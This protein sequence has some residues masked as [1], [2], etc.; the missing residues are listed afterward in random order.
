MVA[1]LVCL[2]LP[3]PTRDVVSGALRSSVMSPLVV[4]QE[5]AELGRRTLLG[6]DAAVIVADS[7]ALRALRLTG[8]EQ[9]NA[10]LRDLLGLGAAL[11][12]GFVPAEALRG[13]GIGDEPT[14][15]ISA[16]RR[17]GV[18]PLAPVVTPQ[19]LL[20]L[21]ERVDADLATVIVWQHPDF[22]VS[23]MS[24]D[25]SAYGMAQAHG[26]TGA[27]RYFL[28]M[29]GVLLR[30]QLKPGD[31]IVTSGLGG[32]FPR[33]IP[34]GS[35][36][37]E[38][39]TP[40]EW[41]RSYLVRPA[42]SLSEAGSVMVLTATRA[43]AGVPNVWAGA[44]AAEEA[45]RRVVAAVDSIARITGAEHAAPAGRGG[46]DSLRARAGRPEP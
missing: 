2:A 34:V 20:G 37:S 29:H 18:E 46:P 41:A 39:R 25:G 36:V 35:V 38:M 21:V 22:R 4:L 16:G 32:V 13:R 6:H 40:G 5:R 43:A 12:W 27:Q 11:K 3:A 33:G 30:A 10:A 15:L 9:E 19:G 17:E 24:V 31:L 45:A 7:L 23:V 1:A 28:D 14:M 8:V 44:A 26:G 42:V